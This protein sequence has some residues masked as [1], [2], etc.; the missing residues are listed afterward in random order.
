MTKKRFIWVVVAIILLAGAAVVIPESPFF[1]PK[2]FDKGTLYEGH[3][4]SYWIGA[5]QS[6]DTELRYSAIRAMGA[7]GADAKEAV[8]V[9]AKIMVEDSDRVARNEA[10]LSLSR[11]TPA[12]AVAVPA[13]AQALE[14]K[15]PIIRMNACLALS[16]LKAEGRAALPSLIKT[17]KDEDN[18]TNASTFTFTIQEI[19]ALAIGRAS[20]G[21]TEGIPALLEALSTARTPEL[22][23]AI[24]RALGEVGEQARSATPQLRK[25]LEDKNKHVSEAAEEALLAIGVDPKDRKDQSRLTEHPVAM[26]LAKEERGYIWEI[27]H[28]GNLLAKHGFGPFAAALETADFPAISKMVADDFAGVDLLDPRK[29]QVNAEF[30]VVE[31]QQRGQSDSQPLDRAAFLARLKESRNIFGDSLPQVKFALM[32]LSPKHRGQLDGPWVGTAQLRLN[33]EQ[34]R[35]APAEVVIHLGYEVP[36]PAQD[37]FARPGWLRSVEVQQVQTAKAPRYLFA[38]VAVERGLDKSKFYDNWNESSFVPVTGGI[39][40]CDFDRDGFLDI[41][42][43]DINGCALYRGLPSGNFEDVTR[44]FGLPSDPVEQSMNAWVDIDGDGWDD[45]ILAGRI[46]R[47]NQG[48]GFEDYSRRTNLVLPNDASG[49]VVADYDRDGKLD[50]Y[51]TRTGPPGDSS[52]LD[53]SNGSSGNTLFRNKGNWQFENVTTAS[54]ARG[55]Y[56]STFT[57]AWL[58]ANNDGWPDLHVINEFGDGVLLINNRNGTFSSHSLADHAVDFGSMGMAVGDIDNDGN[59]DIYCAN[60]YSKAGSRVIGNV[61]PDAYPPNVLKKMRSFVAGSQL[62]LNKGDLKF[63]QAG[64]KMQVAAVGWAYGACL[65]DLDNDGFLDLYATCG[66]ASQDRTEPDG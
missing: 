6:S 40:V 15:E 24:A 22:R 44:S 5:L 7:Y 31:R 25:L 21:T 56:R 61:P 58:D 49:I 17:L 10:A 33:G 34:A 53:G 50:L 65:A 29:V 41:L 1:L 27:E 38:D 32:T 2:L 14:D 63:E 16:R 57:A 52:W 47:N 46:Y 28:H 37:I 35:G 66:F 18:A 8:P 30:A 4:K 12:S 59:I 11:M 36:R 3:P 64:K 51:V 43:T 60:M 48:K 62:H 20:A 19:A 13:L 55:G 54:G 39:Y 23:T 26:E 42:V 9:L 45:L